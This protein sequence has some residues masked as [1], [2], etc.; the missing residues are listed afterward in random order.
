MRSELQATL[1]GNAVKENAMKAQEASI[2]TL[3]DRTEKERTARTKAQYAMAERQQQTTKCTADVEV[4]ER[5]LAL[6]KSE[7]AGMQQ[8]K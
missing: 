4:L 2:K 7:L 5:E 8:A 6:C 3:Q 1:V